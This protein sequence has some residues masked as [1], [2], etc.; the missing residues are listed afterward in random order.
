MSD[1][2]R[3]RVVV[4]ALVALGLL[5]V[6]TVLLRLSRPTERDITPE[7]PREDIGST[8]AG[9][10][11]SG[12]MGPSAERGAV[13]AGFSRDEAGAVAAAVA[14]ASASQR[15]LYWTDGQI[16]EAVAAIAT[17]QAGGRLTDEV[18]ADVRSARDELVESPGRVWWLVHPLAWRVVQNSPDA[19]TVQVWTMTLLSAS[20]V[21]L[22]QTE[23]LTATLE[24]AWV[25]GNWR[26]DAM[27]ETPGPTP[28]T[29]PH[30]EPWQPE[31]FDDALT[32]FT[33]LDGT[34][35]LPTEGP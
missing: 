32:G 2:R 20:D 8:G 31:P 9:E 27:R 6:G 33:R 23:W 16:A 18:L 29:G 13:R 1:R 15:W 22:P 12:E 14:Y 21:A 17:P 26:L 11:D 28:M 30:D 5:V 10:V 25:D 24:L 3:L 34:H 7:T 35:V 4:A 19:A